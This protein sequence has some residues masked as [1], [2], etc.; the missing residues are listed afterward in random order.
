MNTSLS[1]NISALGTIE[2][3]VTH[4]PL[5]SLDAQDIDD[6]ELNISCRTSRSA[7]AASATSRR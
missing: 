7:W 1:A 5:M 6:P 3:F 2:E 4:S